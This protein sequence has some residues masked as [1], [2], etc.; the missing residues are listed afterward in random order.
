M[1]LFNKALLVAIAFFAVAIFSFGLFKSITAE[2]ASTATS[3]DLGTASSFS[4]L[5]KTTVTNVPTSLI[6]GDIGLDNAGG[7]YSGLTSPEVAGTIYSTNSAGP[8]GGLGNNPALMT[9][10]RA[11]NNTAFLD[12]SA[13]SN[14]ACGDSVNADGSS[15]VTTDGINWTG[16]TVDL[17]GKTLVPGIYCAD[18]FQLSGTLTLDDTSAPGGVWIF[19]TTAAAASLVTTP[20]GGAHVVF[21]TNV[22]S[23]CNVWWKVASSATI[24]GGTNFMG[25]ILALTSIS[26]G[27]GATLDGRLL[28]YNGAVTLASNNISGCAAP[29]VNPKLTLDNNVIKNNGGSA[30]KSD[31][32]LTATATDLSL[33]S[34]AG[35]VG[36]TDVATG[37]Y[38]LSESV[39][40]G[41]ASSTWSCTGATVVGGSI[42]LALGDTAVCTITNND[43]APSLTLDKKIVNDNG[44]SAHESD[45]TLTATGTTPISGPG[46]IGLTD[47]VSPSTFATGTYALSES[48]GP[49]GYASSAWSCVKNSAPA[50]DGASIDLALGDIAVCTITNNDIASSGG[51]GYLPPSPSPMINV[52][53]TAS[54]S[55][56]S[57]G[58]GWVNYTFTLTNTGV[59]SVGNIT[60]VDDSCSPVV[61]KSGD[62]NNDNKM[63]LTE[64]W[65]Y[66][67]G[68][69]LSVTHTN[70]VTATA[71]ANNMSVVDT[72]SATVTVNTPVVTKPVAVVTKPVITKP[73][74]SGPVVQE[75]SKVPVVE[76]PALPNTGLSPEENN[77]TVLI[78]GASVLLLATL[79]FAL[80]KKLIN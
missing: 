80:R 46:A 4:I 52:T 18:V 21:K 42:T 14:A 31:W 78:I 36:P 39:V 41:Y 15:G 43:I 68:K 62:V 10:A 19:R 55:I 26:M 13:G 70:T 33:I 12:L 38:A 71:W 56:L 45:W 44:G 9:T 29:H 22:A 7:S 53:K 51:G 3:P 5:A 8:D 34:G 25:N 69:D 2:A 16:T 48:V 54:P 65:V 50:V 74:I 20:G 35:G 28:A 58:S 77:N 27:T 40:P 59:V 79:G 49:A 63:D 64:I 72:A 61:L 67:C 17:A 57:N 75:P 66:T 6:S 32:T 37:T 30:S 24:G 23:A 73:V 76:I 1:K 47:V 11:A 60:M